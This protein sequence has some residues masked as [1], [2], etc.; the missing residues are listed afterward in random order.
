MT[1]QYHKKYWKENKQILKQKRKK[2]YV[3]ANIDL[4]MGKVIDTIKVLPLK[5]LSILLSILI[6]EIDMKESEGNNGK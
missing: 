3:E 4:T 1:K 2:K 5:Q 6:E